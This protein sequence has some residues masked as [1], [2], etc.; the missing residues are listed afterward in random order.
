[1]LYSRDTNASKEEDNNNSV[2]VGHNPNPES[3]EG[4]FQP[5]CFVHKISCKSLA[6]NIP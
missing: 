4:Q 5:H 1:M 2:E 3:G 6:D